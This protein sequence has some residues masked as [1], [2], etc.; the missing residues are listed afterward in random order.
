MATNTELVHFCH[1]VLGIFLSNPL[2][3][4][5]MQLKGK[6]EMIL[7]LAKTNTSQFHYSNSMKIPTRK[8]S[9]LLFI[10]SHIP[11]HMVA[12]ACMLQPIKRR[13]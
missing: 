2:S 7:T 13:G 9:S 12:R 8:N 1:R 4:S 10:D 3:T 11:F 6:T 5:G